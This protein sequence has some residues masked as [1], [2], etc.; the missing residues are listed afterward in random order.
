MLYAI[1]EKYERRTCS[2]HAML[3]GV[4]L[5]A[6][7]ALRLGTL[8]AIR[9]GAIVIV[10]PRHRG[11]HR[12]LAACATCWDCAVEKMPVELLLAGR[13]AVARARTP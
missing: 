5:F 12:V 2:R 8:V 6:R 1:V 10:S 4:V 3:A 13:G 9:P 7:A 11:D